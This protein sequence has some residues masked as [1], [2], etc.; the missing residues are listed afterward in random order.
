M[1][2]VIRISSEECT[3]LIKAS[4]AK[5]YADVKNFLKQK[6]EIKHDFS[7]RVYN[8]D[9]YEFTAIGEEGEAECD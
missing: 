3:E 1:K 9:A 2:F 5:S 7:I 6:Y 4:G 8:G